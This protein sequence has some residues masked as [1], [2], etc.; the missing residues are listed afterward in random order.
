MYNRV[1]AKKNFDIIGL[2]FYY[3]LKKEYSDKWG[4][5]LFWHFS[6]FICAGGG[7]EDNFWVNNFDIYC[8]IF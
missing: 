8:L 6:V 2:D 7:E 4:G 3:G 1:D 5:V